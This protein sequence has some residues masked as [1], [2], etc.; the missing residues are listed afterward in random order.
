MRH[1]FSQYVILQL[2]KGLYDLVEKTIF[3]FLHISYFKNIC[4]I[5]QTMLLH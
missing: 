3:S 1:S 2:Q 4:Y 5:S